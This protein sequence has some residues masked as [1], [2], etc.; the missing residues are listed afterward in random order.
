MMS[1]LTTLSSK[2]ADSC[3]SAAS[4]GKTTFTPEQQEAYISRFTA[5]NQ[6]KDQ[7]IQSLQHALAL[8]Y[9]DRGRGAGGPGHCGGKGRECRRGRGKSPDGDPEVDK[10]ELSVFL[11]DM[12][13]GVE[14]QLATEAAMDIDL[15]APVATLASVASPKSVPPLASAQQSLFDSS[16]DEVSP[17]VVDP[18]ESEQPVYSHPTGP[19]PSPLPRKISWLLLGVGV[20]FAF[21]TVLIVAAALDSLPIFSSLRNTT[22][23]GGGALLACGNFSRRRFALEHFSPSTIVVPCNV[24]VLF[25]VCHGQPQTIE[26][27]APN[28]TPVALTGGFAPFNPSPL[29]SPIVSDLLFTESSAF[30]LSHGHMAVAGDP[31]NFSTK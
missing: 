7:T 16:D 23:L 30:M 9:G 24:L 8:G 27:Q 11:A 3:G 2:P 12:Q 1:Y 10:I 26:Y 22:I 29:V 25:G 18:P 20:F 17:S 31:S 15:D 4:R 19:P 5:Q 14:Q 28:G 21:V 13:A 6:A